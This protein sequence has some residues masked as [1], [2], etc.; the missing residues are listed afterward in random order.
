M[1][2]MSFVKYTAENK[3]GA[4]TAMKR[5]LVKVTSPKASPKRMVKNQ[6]D[7]QPVSVQMFLL[8]DRAACYMPF[9]V[10]TNMEGGSYEDRF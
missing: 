1:P 8:T 10:L 2:A 9:Y 6:C 4:L 5:S 3:S 7:T